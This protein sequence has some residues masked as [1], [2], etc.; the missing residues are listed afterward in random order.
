MHLSFRI[1]QKR[2][3]ADPHDLFSIIR[4]SNEYKRLGWP[5]DRW[6]GWA[7]S[8]FEPHRL[9]SSQLLSKIGIVGV[10]VLWE[11]ACHARF[12]RATHLISVIEEI[13]QDL[14]IP[15]LIGLAKRRDDAVRYVARAAVERLA[16]LR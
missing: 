11:A 6:V 8:S 16:S 3:I 1:L 4:L 10:Y 13:G 7:A 9:R 5:I 2:V 15:A 12:R 14:A